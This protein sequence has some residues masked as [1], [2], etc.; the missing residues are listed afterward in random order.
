[1]RRREIGAGFEPAFW[2]RLTGHV[3]EVRRGAMGCSPPRLRTRS[4]IGIAY[5]IIDVRQNLV[6]ERAVRLSPRRR[7][8][9]VLAPSDRAE[10]WVAPRLRIALDCAAESVELAHASNLAA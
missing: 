5:P 10:P 8:P 6:D 1:M 4:S 3:P 2:P 9:S 7:L